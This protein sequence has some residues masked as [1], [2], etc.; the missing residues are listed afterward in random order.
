VEIYIHLLDLTRNNCEKCNC[1]S[2]AGIEPAALPTPRQFLSTIPIKYYSLELDATKILISVN[3]FI[4][5]MLHV[6]GGASVIAKNTICG[7]VCRMQMPK[8]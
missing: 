3:L 8:E 5:F 2:L 4:L 6:I 7:L 1:R